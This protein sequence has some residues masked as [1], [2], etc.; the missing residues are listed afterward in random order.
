MAVKSGLGRG[1]QALIPED[2]DADALLAQGERIEQVSVSLL[3]PNPQQPRTV[4]QEESLAELAA[5]IRRYGIVQPLVIARAGKGYVIIAG[6]RRWRAAEMA[7]LQTVP[8]IVR[9]MKKQEQLEVA[10][11]ENVQRVDLGPLEQAV[12]IERLHQQF[13]LTYSDIARRLSKSESAL[14]NIVRLLQL[15]PEA[16]QALQQAD[17]TEGHARQILALKDD[18]Q[19]QKELLR[20]IVS[21]RWN[22]RQAER[23]VNSVKQGAQEKKSAQSRVATETPETKRLSKQFKTPVKI[24]RTAKGGRLEL[25]FTSDE[26]LQRLTDELSG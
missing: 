2:F 10:L 13:N 19:Q 3:Q 16:K 22:V 18:P 11:I 26:E 21:Q 23:Y 1:L 14:S 9:T 4:F 7:G 20:L 12:S 8:A 25:Y 5:S 15:P 24:Y 17:I 6:E